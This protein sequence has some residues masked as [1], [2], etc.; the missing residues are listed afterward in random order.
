MR[1][2]EEKQRSKPIQF[3]AISHHHSRTG[4]KARGW[5]S[6]HGA[7]YERTC[8][9]MGGVNSK[10]LQHCLLVKSICEIQVTQNRLS[11]NGI[12]ENSN[13]I[14]NRGTHRDSA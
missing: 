13:I 10:H 14:T 6:D 7:G 3:W 5:Q 2:V 1:P 12:E 8:G 4:S 9:E 11:R